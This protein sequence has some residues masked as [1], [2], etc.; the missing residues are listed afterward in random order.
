[1]TDMAEK[2]FYTMDPLRQ[3]K[4]SPDLKETRMTEKNILANLQ[5][6]LID[7]PVKKGH[8]AVDMKSAPDLAG[9]HIS[10]RAI[11]PLMKI[12]RTFIK[13]LH[14]TRLY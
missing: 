2:N 13:D 3:A 5:D 8:A 11:S 7:L 6:Q 4:Q 9:I 12:R 1:M 14:K 10:I